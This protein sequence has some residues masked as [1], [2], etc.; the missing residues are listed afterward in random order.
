MYLDSFRQ[1]ITLAA[2]YVD[3]IDSQSGNSEEVQGW[4]SGYFAKLTVMLGESL[5]D[6]YAVV[7][8]EIAAANP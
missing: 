3:E 7:D 2:Q 4:L 6:P 5:V 1:L 8:G